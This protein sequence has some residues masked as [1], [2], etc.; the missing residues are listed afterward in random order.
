MT[1]AG[2]APRD[3]GAGGRGVGSDS[4][5]GGEGGVLDLTRYRVERALRQ[6]ARYRY[7][8]PRV[9]R[10]AQGLRIESPC[11]S[12]NVDATGGLIDIAWLARDGE[13]QWCLHARD[14]AARCWVL[15]QRSVE[16]APLLD[17]LCV[18]AE[19]VYWP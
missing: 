6:R 15:R 9:L 4:G 17:A 13:G 8:R 2:R 19:R 10:E 3:A 11:C 16:L 7:V 14:H 18:D 12:R 5:E 1:S